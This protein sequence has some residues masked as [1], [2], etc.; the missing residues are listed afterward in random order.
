VDIGRPS[1]TGGCIC[2]APQNGAPVVT[3]ARSDGKPLTDPYPV[4]TTW[5]VWRA[6]NSSGG[7]ASC[8]QRITVK[9]AGASCPDSYTIT[10]DPGFNLIANQLD[11]GGNRV[12]EVLPLPSDVA[13]ANLFKFDAG[14]Q[15]YTLA[16][17][18]TPGFG[19]SPPSATLVPGEGA[20]LNI[21]A[22]SP[23]NLTFTGLRRCERRLPLCPVQGYQ[24]VSDQLP[25]P[26]DFASIVGLAPVAGTV[27]LQQTPGG[28][29]TNTFN[30]SAWSPAPPTARVGEAWFLFWPVEDA[31]QIV[32]VQRNLWVM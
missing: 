23:V 5:I 6:T 18:F 32:A 16:S 3:G 20:Y 14:T 25:E 30:G 27:V 22:P 12:N 7:F 8:S 26:G 31:L 13:E 11:N 4:G 9:C 19:W 21:E 29:V 17:T 2:S 15:N 10:V 28:F 1:A 24:L